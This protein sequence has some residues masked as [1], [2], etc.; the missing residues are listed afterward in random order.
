VKFAD[1]DL[2]GFPIRLNVGDRGL[3]EGKVELKPR[4]ASDAELLPL[5]GVLERVSALLQTS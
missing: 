2:I 1:A 3:K 4:K 5:E